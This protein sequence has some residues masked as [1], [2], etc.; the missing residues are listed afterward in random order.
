[1]TIDVTSIPRKNLGFYCANSVS[2][3]DLIL[4]ETDFPQNW[5]HI[6]QFEKPFEDR[7]RGIE[8][9]NCHSCSY[10]AQLSTDDKL[11]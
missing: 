3:V 7:K 1:M 10:C 8:R 5:F 4:R 9:E 2:P 6:F 11:W